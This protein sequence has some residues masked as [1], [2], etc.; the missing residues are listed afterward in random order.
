MS[1]P[2][3]RKL[4]VNKK[5][6]KGNFFVESIWPCPAIVRYHIEMPIEQDG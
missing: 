1:G 4:H 6:K 2:I 5:K 3:P